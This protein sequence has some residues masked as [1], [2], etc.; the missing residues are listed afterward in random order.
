MTVNMIII[1]CS[2]IVAIVLGTYPIQS[3]IH[4]GQSNGWSRRESIDSFDILTS[5]CLIVLIFCIGIMLGLLI[6]TMVK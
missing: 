1:I 3:S 2:L 6:V 5:F 4:V